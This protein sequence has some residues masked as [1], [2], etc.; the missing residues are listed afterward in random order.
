MLEK[1]AMRKMPSKL[2]RAS[3]D[4]PDEGARLGAVMVSTRIMSECQSTYMNLGVITH[5]GSFGVHVPLVGIFE[6]T[7]N[8]LPVKN[9]PKITNN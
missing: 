6:N 2:N 5:D 8:R 4:H 9:K 3:F 7:S 1:S